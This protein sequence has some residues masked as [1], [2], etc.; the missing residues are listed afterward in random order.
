MVSVYVNENK[1]PSLNFEK[2]F[3]PVEKGRGFPYG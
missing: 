1:Y 3:L 2:C